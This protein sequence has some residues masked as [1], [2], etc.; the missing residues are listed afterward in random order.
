MTKSFLKEVESTRREKVEKRDLNFVDK[1]EERGRTGGLERR[2][3]HVT[4]R[5]DPRTET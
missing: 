4:F 1:E 2:L 3:V 5:G